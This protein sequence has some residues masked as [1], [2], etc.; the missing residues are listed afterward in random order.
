MGNDY[1]AF[2]FFCSAQAGIYANIADQQVGLSGKVGTDAICIIPPGLTTTTLDLLLRYGTTILPKDLGSNTTLEQ[3]FLVF[4][5]GLN[6]FHRIFEKNGHSLYTADGLGF[7]VRWSIPRLKNDAQEDPK[8]QEE[9]CKKYAKFNH[10]AVEDCENQPTPETEDFG[11]SGE[12]EVSFPVTLSLT[13]IGW[14]LPYWKAIEGSLDFSLSLY[15]D[16]DLTKLGSSWRA[17]E[18]MTTDF[19]FAVTAKYHFGDTI[20]LAPFRIDKDLSVIGDLLSLGVV[21]VFAAPAARERLAAGI[22]QN[23][24]A[25]SGEVPRNQAEAIQTSAHAN[26]AVGVVAAETGGLILGVVAATSRNDVV[27]YGA[28]GVG[29]VDA[30]ILL[31]DDRYG[32]AGLPMLTGPLAGLAYRLDDRLLEDNWLFPSA[33]LALEVANLGVALGN[34]SDESDSLPAA[35]RSRSFRTMALMDANVL[36]YFLLRYDGIRYAAPA[37]PLISMAIACSE[38]DWAMCG[39]S[40]GNTIIIGSL[41]AFTD[42]DIPLVVAP[43]IHENGAPGLVA[44][45]RF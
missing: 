44:G 19:G 37:G 32:A 25:K 10:S 26:S 28:V 30:G 13:P 24:G 18:Q 29:I 39:I 1:T 31:A 42:G 7:N 6:N 20:K 45:G 34:L 8:Q 11:I 40:V 15:A 12:T 4:T 27:G 5:A 17:E 14:W 38:E 36:P 9:I 3:Q 22:A 33:V 41:T 35:E 43:T 2:S 21:S 16:L 23:I